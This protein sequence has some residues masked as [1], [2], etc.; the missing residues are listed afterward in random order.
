MQDAPVMS[1]LLPLTRLCRKP[2]RL[3][4][5][6]REGSL[7]SYT[8]P[9]PFRPAKEAKGTERTRIAPYFNRC[10]EASEIP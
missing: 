5:E 9:L 8:E 6:Y 7:D 4:V 10:I 2:W 1:D 3:N